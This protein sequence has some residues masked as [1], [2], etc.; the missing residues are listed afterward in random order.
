MNN[1]LKLIVRISLPLQK[2]RV[3]QSGI[4]FFPV[5]NFVHRMAKIGNGKWVQFITLGLEVTNAPGMAK[6]NQSVSK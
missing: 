2:A 3:L 4:E 6:G 1:P 5:N